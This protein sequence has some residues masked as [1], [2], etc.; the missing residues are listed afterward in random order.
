VFGT[1]VA[2]VEVDAESGEVK[3]QRYVAVDDVGL[4]AMPLA[5]SRAER[6]RRT[7]SE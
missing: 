1:H 4:N 3:I 7:R 6:A 5:P 2:V